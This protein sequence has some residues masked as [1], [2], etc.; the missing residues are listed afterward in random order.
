MKFRR[1]LDRQASTMNKPAL[2]F[3]LLAGVLGCT[4]ASYAEPAASAPDFHFTKTLAGDTR[5]EVYDQNGPITIEGAP[6]DALEVSAVKTGR[7]ADLDRV[8]VVAREE[9]GT[10]VVCALWP[11][12]DECHPGS[13]PSGHA[14]DTHVRVE[15]RVRVPSK[16]NG[17]VARTMNGAIVAQSPRGD[18]KLDTLNG[19][20]SVSAFGAITAQTLNGAV[21]ARSLGA[22]DIK[23]STHN[24]RV[25]LFLPDA[26]GADVEAS[27]LN[28][29][30][31][32]ELGVVPP[33]SIPRI[34]EVKMRFGAGGPRVSLRTLN[35]DVA[36]SRTKS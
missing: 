1:A 33:P 27:T 21:V 29:R 28:G 30:V 4:S 22:A 26:A 3:A 36:I 9:G 13:A 19:S 5:L 18:V 31:S 32:S 24:G 10:I 2:S 23:L 20:I 12:Q 17:L 35:G 25:E 8:R 15:I 11:G 34:H 14:D 6:G 7:A 16:V